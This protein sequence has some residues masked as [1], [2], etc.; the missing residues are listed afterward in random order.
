MAEENRQRNAPDTQI[1]SA[2]VANV[3]D[4]PY[5]DA[6]FDVVMSFGLLEHFEMD[7]LRRLIEESIR[8]LK[9]GG[10]FIADIVPGL[11]RYNARTFSQVINFLAS[12]M[13]RFLKGRWQEL[14]PLYREYFDQYFETT[15]DD[16]AWAA[17]LTE[18]ELKNVRVDVC[19][20]FPIL[21]L[22]GRA[23]QLYTGLINRNLGFHQRFDGANSWFTRRWGWMYLSSGTKEEPH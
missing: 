16:R 7:S 11:K 15:Y 23:E 18:M 13:L 12:A 3:L 2:S 20:P 21:A 8:V 14:T 6:S 9:P 19:R 22:S 1:A 17:L 5:G 4:L 10:L